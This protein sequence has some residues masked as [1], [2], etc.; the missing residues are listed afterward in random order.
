MLLI[1]YYLTLQHQA[2][3]EHWKGKLGHANQERETLLEQA[4]KLQAHVA[5]LQL[6]VRSDFITAV[7]CLYISHL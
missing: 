3:E 6:Q 1:A 5:E 7:P 4:A 2:S